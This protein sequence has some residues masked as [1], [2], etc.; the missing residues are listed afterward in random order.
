MRATALAAFLCAILP[1]ADLRA[2][3]ELYFDTCR[4]HSNPSLRQMVRAGRIP[5]MIFGFGKIGWWRSATSFRWATGAPLEDEERSDFRCR[6]QPLHA[7]DYLEETAW[8]EGVPG[9]GIGQVLLAVV[10]RDGPVSI[11]AGEGRSDSA[12]AASNRPRRIRLS[13]FTTDQFPFS[14]NF[15]F[16]DA[17]N[18]RR[19]GEHEVELADTNGYQPLSLPAFTPVPFEW[20][21]E[22]HLNE[23]GEWLVLAIEILSVYPGRPGAHTCI[24]EITKRQR[25][26]RPR[27]RRRPSLGRGPYGTSHRGGPRGMRR[28]PAALP[29]LTKRPLRRPRPV[30]SVT[31]T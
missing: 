4:R 6:Y 1:P 7:A 24:S 19:G 12:F 10:A 2:Q 31:S 27:S 14:N 18:L 23:A 21:E 3:R 28:N 15:G 8:C 11:W 16:R 29:A 26:R 13:V 22:D 30:C 25:Y 20:S 17:R 9:V 5:S